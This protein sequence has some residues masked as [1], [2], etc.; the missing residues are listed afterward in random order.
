M[1][2]NEAIWDTS[3]PWNGIN[4]RNKER[5]LVEP[6]ALAECT[7]R[8]SKSNEISGIVVNFSTDGIGVAVSAKEPIHVHELVWVKHSGESRAGT[9]RHISADEVVIVGIA[10]F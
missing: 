10:W 6:D 1:T 9:V 8:T 5:Q 2:R 4:R 7:I 3:N